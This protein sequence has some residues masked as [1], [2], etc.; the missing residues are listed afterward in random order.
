MSRFGRTMRVRCE[1]AYSI[2]SEDAIWMRSKRDRN[3]R[4]NLRR[5]LASSHPAISQTEIALIA[6]AVALGREFRLSGFLQN[7]P[8]LSKVRILGDLSLSSPALF[9]ENGTCGCVTTP[10]CFPRAAIQSINIRY[11]AEEGPTTRETI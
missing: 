8:S 11:G 2:T 1:A 7:K 5:G 6:A 9:R 10:P 3:P 4:R